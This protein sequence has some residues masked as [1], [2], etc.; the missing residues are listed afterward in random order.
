MHLFRRSFIINA[1]VLMISGCA[2][3]Y[4]VQAATIYDE[5]VS[6]DLSDSGLNPTTLNFTSGSNRVFGMTGRGT[7]QDRDYFTFTVPTG[8]ALTS[9]TLLPGTTT[10]NLSF[11]GLQA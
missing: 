4:S 3:D 2:L 9:M 10:Q 1:L 6:G 5:A 7:T 11:V 8:L